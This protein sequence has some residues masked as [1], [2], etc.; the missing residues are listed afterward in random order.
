MLKFGKIQNNSGETST[1][2]VENIFP[3][4]LLYNVHEIAWKYPREEKRYSGFSNSVRWQAKH[5]V[6]GSMSTKTNK[7]AL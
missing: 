7:K 6:L 5:A 2:R 3:K 4:Y 1:H